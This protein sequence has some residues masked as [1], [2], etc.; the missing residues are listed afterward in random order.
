M[1]PYISFSE[2]LP[3]GYRESDLKWSSKD[4]NIA[5]INS[6]GEVTGRNQGSTIIKV[7]TSDNKYSVECT[8]T[9]YEDNTI[10]FEPLE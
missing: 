2:L 8:V 6:R 4:E 10:V 7:F 3:E 1:Y 9:V 5:V